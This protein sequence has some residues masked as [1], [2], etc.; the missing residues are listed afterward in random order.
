MLALQVFFLRVERDLIVGVALGFH[1]FTLL[2]PGNDDIASVSA[3]IDDG[4]KVARG[5]VVEVASPPLVHLNRAVPTFGALRID[6][7]TAFLLD[8]ICIFYLELSRN[9][10]PIV[11]STPSSSRSRR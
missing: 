11:T 7:F 10:I 6:E 2:L 9:S 4:A 3:N 5:G 8:V 1:F